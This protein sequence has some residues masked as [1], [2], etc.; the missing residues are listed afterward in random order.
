S[1]RRTRRQLRSHSVEDALGRRSATFTYGTLSDRTARTPPRLPHTGSKPNHD[2]EGAG[3]SLAATNLRTCELFPSRPIPPEPGPYDGD[4][5]DSTTQRSAV[6]LIDNEA[7]DEHGG[8]HDEDAV[9][10]ESQPGFQSRSNAATE[11]AQKHAGVDK[12]RQQQAGD[13]AHHKP[14]HVPWH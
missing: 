14:F 4:G 13:N 1:L 8:Q 10:A 3:A 7:D 9:P 12:P 6:D 2:R 5:M 11:G